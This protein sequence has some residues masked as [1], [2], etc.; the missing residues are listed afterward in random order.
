MP[1]RRPS[2]RGRAWADR[3]RAYVQPVIHERGFVSFV[4]KR[5]VFLA[6]TSLATPLF[7]LHDVELCRPPI[8]GLA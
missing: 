1:R 6:G 8:G 4:L 7:P 3:L 2:F 5:F